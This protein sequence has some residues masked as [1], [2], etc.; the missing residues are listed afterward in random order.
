MLQCFFHRSSPRISDPPNSPTSV[1]LPVG[2]YHKKL[3]REESILKLN[4]EAVGSYLI[5]D[6]STEY[7]S[8]TL[9]FR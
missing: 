4:N 1:G 7:G 2:W 9:S 3:S 8:Y 5:R 6:C